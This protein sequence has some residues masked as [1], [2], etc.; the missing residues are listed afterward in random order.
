ML[1]GNYLTNCSTWS[2]LLSRA[3]IRSAWVSSILQ[4]PTMSAGAAAAPVGQHSRKPYT[5][6]RAVLY[7]LTSVLASNPILTCLPET[8][9]E[10]ALW[11]F[12]RTF[13]FFAANSVLN[14]LIPEIIILLDLP[15]WL[16]GHL[17]AF[18][19]RVVHYFLCL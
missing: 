3:L 12:T 14:G 15:A 4:N 9:T 19:S 17:S 10:R 5:H 1:R 8:P 2:N 7:F 13:D 6:G 11:P 16:T 18:L